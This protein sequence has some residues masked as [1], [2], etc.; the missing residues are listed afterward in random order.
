[1]VRELLFGTLAVLAL[2]IA[3]LACSGPNSDVAPGSPAAEATN[4]RR[5]AV[6]D[7]QR[8][9][10]NKPTPTPPP[11]ATATPTPTCQNAIWWTE[12]R[13]HVGESRIVQGTVVAIR[14]L[15]PGSALLELGQPYPDPTGLSVVV[16]ATAAANLTGQNVCISGHIAMAQGRPVVNVGDPASIQVIGPAN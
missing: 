7:V 10:A 5:T 15:S 8:I 1:M 13:S 14:T 12:A 6:A 9:I 4:A 11:A 3:G 16:S 2:A